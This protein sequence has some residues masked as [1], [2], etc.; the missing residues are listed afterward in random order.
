MEEQ[1]DTLKAIRDSI[2][3]L[4]TPQGMNTD[5]TKQELPTA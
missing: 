4:G 5:F 2:D 3:K 1:L